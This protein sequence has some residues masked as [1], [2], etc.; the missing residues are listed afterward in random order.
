[1]KNKKL[2]V[3]LVLVIGTMSLLCGCSTTPPANL[4]IEPDPD[5]PIQ[6]TW[7]ALIS[8]RVILVVEG[9]NWTQYARYGTLGAE[10]RRTSLGK[11]EKR[12][13]DF[14]TGDERWSVENDILTIGKSQYERYIK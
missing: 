3:I 14:Y 8:D 11:I 12:G 2:F 6:G 9:T 7:V 5:N 1:M 10:W 13:D 4:I